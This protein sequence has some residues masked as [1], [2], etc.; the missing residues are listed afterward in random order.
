MKI[1]KILNNNT[2]LVNDKGVEKIVIGSGIGFQKR[3]N[4]IVDK[5]KIEKV[6]VMEDKSEYEKFEEI[7]KSYPQEYVDVA[8]N[9]IHYAEQ[10]LNVELN[11]HIYIALTD[12]LAFAFERLKKGIVVQN[13]LLEE[14]RSLY[15][16][17]F[18]IGIWAKDYIK[19]KLNIEIPDDEIGFIALHIHTA[20]NNYRDISVTMDI[21]SI[22]KDMTK[23]IEASLNIKID[24][25][26]VSY[27]RLKTHFHFALKR[28]IK[29]ER[30]F[31]IDMELFEVIKNKYSKAYN[32]AKNIQK[33]I[34]EEYDY[35]MPDEE[36]AYISLHIQRIINSA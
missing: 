31:G 23:I 24:E 3:V 14:I 25:A 16:D 32:I 35:T 8:E 6:F 29:N 11:P 10:K 28:I 17:E 4:D 13:K 9:I 7:V 5:T 21:A 15:F 22:I 12:H 33:H 1:K 2:L 20:K 34:Y 19:Q 18:K 26:S 36:L 30:T 27:Q